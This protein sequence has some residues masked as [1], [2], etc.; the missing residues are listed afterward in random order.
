MA[1]VGQLY[2]QVLIG[3]SVLFKQ[4]TVASRKF[5]DCTPKSSNSTWRY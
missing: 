3:I 1:L 2:I 5:L 4:I